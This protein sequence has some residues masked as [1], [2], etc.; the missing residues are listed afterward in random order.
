M[1]DQPIRPPPVTGYVIVSGSTSDTIALGG[2]T[3]ERPL[4]SSVHRD[5]RTW[6]QAPV[7]RPDSAKFVPPKRGE[8]LVV[9]FHDDR[10]WGPF[11][12][13]VAAGNWVAGR[14]GGGRVLEV[15]AQ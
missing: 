4:F 1:P 15:T 12:N 11:R 13:A 9:V 10:F 8:K 3:L 2:F 7:Y 14:P 5:G 6:R